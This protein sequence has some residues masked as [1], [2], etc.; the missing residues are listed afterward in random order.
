MPAVSNAV[1]RRSAVHPLGIASLK[2]AL[3][4]FV[5]ASQLAHLA[6]H[7]L[8]KLTG[9]AV[10]GSAANSEETHLFFNGFVAVWAMA[11]VWA[12]PRNPWV[13]PLAL[14]S[15]F[16]GIEH[17][18]IFEQYLRTGVTHGPGLLGLGGAIG[19][20]PLNRLDL[21]N[22]YNGF[23]MILMVLGLWNETEAL[24]AERAQ[25]GDEP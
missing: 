6:E 5:F 16:H 2:L 15:I 22:V 21:H 8:I 4:G 25:L 12:F 19:W 24:L 20:I 23:E 14:L 13:Y 17:A 7:I 18:Y 1:P 11:L 10:L 9:A 3:F